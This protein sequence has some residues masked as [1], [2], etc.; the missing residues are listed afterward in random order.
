MSPRSQSSDWECIPRGSASR[1]A[2]GGG[3]SLTGSQPGQGLYLNLVPFGQE[4]RFFGLLTFDSG[5][6]LALKI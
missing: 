2:T 3:A 4:S 1:Q 6:P 5:Q